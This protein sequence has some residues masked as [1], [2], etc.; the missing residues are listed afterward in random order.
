[1]VPLE[2]ERPDGGREGDEDT[3]KEDAPADST[4]WPRQA[5]PATDL[6][7]GIENGDDGGGEGHRL[8]VLDATLAGPSEAPAAAEGVED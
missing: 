2:D 4:V 5:V 6:S 8:V 3:R 1:M 7:G